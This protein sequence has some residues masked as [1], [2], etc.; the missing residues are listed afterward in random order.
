MIRY[1]DPDAKARAEAPDYLAARDA[2][3]KL[4]ILSHAVN[5]AQRDL[6]NALKDVRLAYAP[7]GIDR[8]RAG[9]KRRTA[10]AEQ[11]LL[12]RNAATLIEQAKLVRAI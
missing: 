2:L 7:S 10:E 8:A 12:S 9:M 11:F 5:D 1:P 4:R 3:S 6:E